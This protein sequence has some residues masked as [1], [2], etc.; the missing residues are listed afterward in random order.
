M[1][2]DKYIFE[3][4]DGGSQ[5]P[6]ASYGPRH[7]VPSGEVECTNCEY[8]DGE[9][10]HWDGDAR[11]GEGEFVHEFRQRIHLKG[12]LSEAQKMRLLEIA[13][14]CP[15]HRALME[16]NV[17]IEELVDSLIAEEG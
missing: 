11:E 8:H 13:G 10:M 3:P 9:R 16:P 1:Q 7:E 5:P 12:D 2:Y 15:V 6:V 14:K 4:H 17:A